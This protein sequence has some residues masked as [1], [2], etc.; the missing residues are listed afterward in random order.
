MATI[1]DVREI[2]AWQLSMELATEIYKIT[3][4]FPKNEQFGLTSQIQRAIVSVPSNIAE[5]FDRGSNLEFKRFLL[6]ARG[7]ITEVQTQLEIAKNL[8]YIKQPDF[9]LIYE[10]TVTIHKLANG[11]I[12]HLKTTC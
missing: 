7:S 4:S 5:G 6:I 10:K 8:G 3:N 1:K 11:L 2:K 12:K 9:T